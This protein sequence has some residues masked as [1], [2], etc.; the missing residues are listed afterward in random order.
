MSPRIIFDNEL[1]LLRENV[2]QMARKVEESYDELFKALAE[3]DE[4]KIMELKKNDKAVSKKQREIESQCLFLITKQQPIVGDLRVVTASLKVVTDIER[5]GDHVSDMADLLL[6]LQMKDLSLFSVHVETM[7]MATREMLHEA[8][9]MFI[10]RDME[11]AKRVI[12][13]DDIIDECFNK[14][15]YDLIDSLKREVK[16][17]DECIDVLMLAKYLE[18]IGDHAVNIGEWEIF[19]ETGNISDMRLL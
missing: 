10:A 16:D 2:A 5:V 18:K 13:E 15:K 11:A 9:E 8:V 19:Q 3:Q 12:R 17:A 4:N 6:R 1:K 7:I 14:V